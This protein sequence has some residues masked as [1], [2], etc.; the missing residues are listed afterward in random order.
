ML[1]LFWLKFVSIVYRYLSRENNRDRSS[2]RRSDRHTNHVRYHRM[3]DPQGNYY[4]EI[5]RR[6]VHRFVEV[7]VHRL[8]LYSG[9]IYVRSAK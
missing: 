3:I 9:Y 8:P 4:G 7:Y 5:A 1:L 6:I 2:N